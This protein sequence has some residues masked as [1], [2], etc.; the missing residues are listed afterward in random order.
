VEIKLGFSFHSPAK[1]RV[2]PGLATGIQCSH[3]TGF[4]DSAASGDPKNDKVFT[5]ND[6]ILAGA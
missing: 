2:V 4:S 5:E 1:Q 3:I 6:S